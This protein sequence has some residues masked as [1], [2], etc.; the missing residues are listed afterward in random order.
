MAEE[1]KAQEKTEQPTPKRLKEA[2][3][4]GQVARSREL[5]TMMVLMVSAGAFLVIGGQTINGLLNMMGS[6]FQSDRGLVMSGNLVEVLINAV[7]EALVILMPFFLLVFAAALF[8]PMLLSGWSFSAKA[9]AFKVDKLDPIKGVKRI[10]S[11]KSL[12]ELI[13]ALAK[14]SV[15][16]VIALLL[17]W[18][19]VDDF[20]VLGKKAV[21]VG[22]ADLG[23]ILGW[24]FL[25]LSS[26]MIF[27]AGIDVPFQLWDHTRQLKMSRQEVKDEYKETD[28]SPELK[29]RIRE[30][31]QEMAQRRMMEEVPRADV[32]ITNPTHYAVALKYDQSKTG[33]PIVVAKGKDLIALQIRTLATSHQ[34]PILS[35]PPLSRALYFSTELNQEIPAG[36]YVAVAQVLAYIYQLKAKVNKFSEAP[37]TMDDLPIPDDLQHE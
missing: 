34:V 6:V 17:L 11:V 8:S 32:V 24:S 35:A 29:R 1:D 19:N 3:E 26:A 5:G 15:V 12:M 13:K 16:L 7:T 33:A 10:F 9:L 25:A 36:L 2:R 30:V 21:E 37:L 31:Q 28:G 23:T 20:L 14:F 27:I 18:N 4:K 22:L